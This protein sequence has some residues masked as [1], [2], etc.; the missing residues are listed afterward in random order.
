VGVGVRGGRADHIKEKK[1]CL[2][3]E[4][5]FANILQEGKPACQG[6]LRHQKSPAQNEPTEDNLTGREDLLGLLKKT[7]KKA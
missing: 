2:R 5:E 1:K 4:K 3:T 6:T 7:S